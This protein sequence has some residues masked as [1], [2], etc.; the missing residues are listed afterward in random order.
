MALVPCRECGNEISTEA[1]SCPHCGVINPVVAEPAGPIKEKE[2]E[3]EQWK[4]ALGWAIGGFGLLVVF[5]IWTAISS[6]R[7]SHTSASLRTTNS[8]YMA[9]ATQA[10]LE[11]LIKFS[12]DRD[13]A[14]LE[15]VARSSSC[16]PLRPGLSV[17][18]SESSGIGK[19][20][21]RPLG[22][23]S[24]VWTLREAID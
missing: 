11:R 8:G 20:C 2:Q 7:R 4:A 3:K 10:E 9:C 13:Q 23:I 12:A 22:Q 6:G 17:Y 14:A 21:V 16:T 5:L 1:P 15:R 24:C 18:I 19:V